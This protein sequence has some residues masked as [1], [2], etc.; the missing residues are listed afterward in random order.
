L[1][2]TDGQERFGNITCSLYQGMH[3]THLAH[4][5]AIFCFFLSSQRS[6]S[7]HLF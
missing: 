6:N 5:P 2:D 3:G 4:S 1:F 7:C